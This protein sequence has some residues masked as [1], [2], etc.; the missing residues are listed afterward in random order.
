MLLC[1]DLIN[2]F[3]AGELLVDLYEGL[4]FLWYCLLCDFGNKVRKMAI[5]IIKLL[6]FFRKKHCFITILIEI[7]G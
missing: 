2:L 4:Q 5:G 6:N 1:E 7:N 3:E